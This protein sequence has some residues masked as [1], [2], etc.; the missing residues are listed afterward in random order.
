MSA[1]FVQKRRRSEVSE[2]GN[3]AFVTLELVHQSTGRGAVMPENYDTDAER[4]GTSLIQPDDMA[5]DS[6][7][8]PPWNLLKEGLPARWSLSI[9]SMFGFVFLYALRFNIS[10]ALIAMT[11][12]VTLYC[13][14]Q[15][16]TVS[17]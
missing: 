14:N 12:N 2:E 3:Q 7:P 4:E 13:H 6:Y 15:S 11:G 8:R 5:G 9:L 17:S 10:Q 1:K 16:Y